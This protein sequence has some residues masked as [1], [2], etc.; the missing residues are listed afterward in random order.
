MGKKKI[1]T[2]KEIKHLFEKEVLGKVYGPDFNFGC[3]L[4]FSDMDN[5]DRPEVKMI[6][7]QLR[8][9]NLI[10]LANALAMLIKEYNSPTKEFFFRD[11]MEEILLEA[12]QNHEGGNA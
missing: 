4:L 6:S 9:N 7:N 10:M 12:V 2:D 8:P 3:I 11:M 5:K 1:W